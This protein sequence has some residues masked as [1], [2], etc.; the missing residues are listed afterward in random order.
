MITRF[1]SADRVS[2]IGYAPTTREA[3]RQVGITPAA[4]VVPGDQQAPPAPD[5]AG[6]PA[7]ATPAPNQPPQQGDSPERDDAANAI[8]DAITALRQAQQSGD[9]AAY[10]EALDQL[11]QAVARYESLA[12]PN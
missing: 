10:G 4:G 1:E 6:T 5:Q 8:S 2:G 7:P 11:S 9:F 12:A 3:L